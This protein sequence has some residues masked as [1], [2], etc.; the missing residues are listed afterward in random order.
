MLPWQIDPF[1]SVGT[2]RSIRYQCIYLI[3]IV[4]VGGG[5]ERERN[6]RERKIRLYINTLLYNIIYVA[7]LFLLMEN[8]S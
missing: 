5:R 6:Y 7:R 2:L 3:L 8:F 1:D 4:S